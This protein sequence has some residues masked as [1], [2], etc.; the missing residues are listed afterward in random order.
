MLVEKLAAAGRL[1]AVVALGFVAS[2]CASSGRWHHS[3]DVSIESP[4]GAECKVDRLGTTIG[5]VKATPGR[6]NVARSKDDVSRSCTREGYEQSN[7]VLVSSFTGAT[8][9]NLR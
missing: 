8:V 4:P 5:F 6:V 9:G 2:A 1:A 3:Q 7:E